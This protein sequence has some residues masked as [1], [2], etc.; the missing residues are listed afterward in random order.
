MVIPVRPSNGVYLTLDDI[1]E[2]VIPADGDIHSA[3]TALISLEN[4]IHGAIHPYEEIVK[5]SEFARDNNLIL[6]CDGA[7]LYNASIE[8]GISL[9]EYGALFDSISICLSKS[10]GAPVGSVLVGDSKFITKANHFRKQ[11][12][13]GI[14]QSGSLAAMASAAIDENEKKIKATHDKAK[15]VAEYLSKKGIEFD[16]PVD[17]NFI[18][19]DVRKSPIDPDLAE[20]YGEEFNVKMWLPRI[21]FHYQLSDEAIERMKEAV[22]KTFEETKK[23]PPR[24]YSGKYYK[25]KSDK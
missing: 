7:R 1:L 25:V 13:G 5:I 20:K 17:T 3:P 10:L 2:N 11:N 4:T 15:E 18:F 9:A 8:S 22:V 16:E 14:R 21:T 24:K 23:L 19:I 12:G 6:H